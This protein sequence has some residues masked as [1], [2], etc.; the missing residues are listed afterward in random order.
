MQKEN[1]SGAHSILDPFSKRDCGRR[2]KVRMKKQILTIMN[3]PPKE[4]QLEDE[5]L[6]HD[7]KPL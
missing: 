6:I 7:D 1:E 3:N 4:L 2:T 5:E